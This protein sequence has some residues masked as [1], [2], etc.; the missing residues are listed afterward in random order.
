MTTMAEFDQVFW[1]EYDRIVERD[2]IVGP[3]SKARHS[4]IHGEA[5]EIACQKTGVKSAPCAEHA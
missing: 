5:F 1:I 4:V 2:K 3:I